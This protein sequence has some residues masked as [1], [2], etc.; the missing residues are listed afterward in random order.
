MKLLY[1]L[2]FSTL[3]FFLFAQNHS[4]ENLK[5]WNETSSM[6]AV[7][8][9][10][11]GEKTEYTF[12]GEDVARFD[13]GQILANHP[14]EAVKV[15]GSSLNNGILNYYRFDSRIDDAYAPCGNFV[16][17]LDC[18]G[19]QAFLGVKTAGDEASGG[20]TIVEVRPNTAAE[21]SDLEVGDL[22]IAVDDDPIIKYTDLSLEIRKRKVG[23]AIVLSVERAGTIVEIPATL[24]TRSHRTVRFIPSCENHLKNDEALTALETSS[25]VFPNPTAGPLTWNIGGLNDSPAVMTLSDISGKLMLSQNVFPTNNSL[26]HQL[27]VSNLMKGSYILQIQQDNITIKEKILVVN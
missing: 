9:P 7:A 24:G 5:Q 16:P 12:K 11:D 23:Q 4:D 14:D 10:E 13:L 25:N 2:L 27:D 21:S 1:T 19:S 20:A 8:T 15:Y 26:S 6:Y 18:Q 17:M 3:P 22:V